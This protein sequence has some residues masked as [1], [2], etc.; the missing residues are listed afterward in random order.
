MHELFLYLNI[1]KIL[2]AL[3]LVNKIGKPHDQIL[4]ALS[5]ATLF[6]MKKGFTPVPFTGELRK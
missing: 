4:F 6:F 3:W 5:Y 1:T 2:R